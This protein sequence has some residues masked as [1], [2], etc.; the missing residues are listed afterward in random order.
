LQVDPKQNLPT[1]EAALKEGGN[2]DFQVRE[3]AGLN[4][5]FQHCQTG[6]PTEYNKIDETF[7]PE[8]LEMIGDWILSK[9]GRQQT[10]AN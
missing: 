4:H 8:A 10:D 5:L 2:S 7:S 1:I 6:S 3:L 9:T